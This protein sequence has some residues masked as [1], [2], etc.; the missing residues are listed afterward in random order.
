MPDEPRERWPRVGCALLAAGDSR[1]L[2]QPKQLIDYRGVPLVRHVAQTALAA[3]CAA[4][5]VV[6]GSHA[7]DVRAALQGLPVD[8]LDN[9]AWTEGIAASI[10]VA[11]GWARRL[12]LDALLLAACDQWRL[13]PEHLRRLIARVQR[14]TDAAASVYAETCGVPALFG[15]AWF[16]RLLSLRGDRG[17]GSLLRA[18]AATQRVPWPGGAFDL[19]TEQDLARMADA[20]A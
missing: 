8:M 1:R 17:A 4:C 6:V 20:P 19:D 15:A 9:S 12:Q 11:V 16:P 5:A 13:T 2:G 14:P 10:R 18:C 7:S 3:R